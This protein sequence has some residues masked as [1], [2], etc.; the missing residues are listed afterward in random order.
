MPGK[1]R[2]VEE[3]WKCSV[4]GGPRESRG[5]PIQPASE[6]ANAADDVNEPG[7]QVQGR[8]STMPVRASGALLGF[9][10]MV[11]VAEYVKNTL[12]ALECWAVV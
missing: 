9:T 3:N 1:P 6:Q 10:R 5:C 11:G 8:V 2:A 12:Q 7:A 4:L